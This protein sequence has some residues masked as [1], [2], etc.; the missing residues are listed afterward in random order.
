[1]N[2]TLLF[3]EETCKE[4]LICR[5]SSKQCC[6]RSAKKACVIYNKDIIAEMDLWPKELGIIDDT[7][8]YYELVIMPQEDNRLLDKYHLEKLG[9]PKDSKIFIPWYHYLWRYRSHDW[10]SIHSEAHSCVC[11]GQLYII[12]KVKKGVRKIIEKGF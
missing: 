12:F 4:S 1:M 5:L 10:P 11:G 8:T 9:L 2:I 7:K 3:P 6:H